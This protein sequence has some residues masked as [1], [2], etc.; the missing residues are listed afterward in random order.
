[1]F[2]GDSITDQR[3]YTT[4]TETFVLTRFPDRKIAFTHSGWG[5]D[6]VTGGAGGGIA[7]RLDRDVFPYQPTVVTIML[8]MND[9]RV[10]AFD[11]QI[12]DIYSNGYRNIIKQL[13]TNLPNARIT[14]IQPSPY[15]DVT[16]EPRFPGGYNAV[17]LRYSD[18]LATLAQAEKLTLADLAAADKGS[19]HYG[20]SGKY[21]ALMRRKNASEATISS[22]PFIPSSR[23]I[24]PAY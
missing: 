11:Q 24:Q 19:F 13:K 23:L 6:R 1:M 14:A 2:F 16:Q 12:F 18:F 22:I 9:G 21:W 5:G 15:D 3:L 10:R 4:F 8:G 20:R 17:L 7:Q